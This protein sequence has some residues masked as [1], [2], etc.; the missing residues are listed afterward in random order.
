[1]AP[2]SPSAGACSSPDA[3]PCPTHCRQFYEDMLPYDEFSV[4]L[5]NEDIPHLGRLLRSIDNAE[6]ERL[7]EGMRRWAVTLC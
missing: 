3:D 5:G 4:R 6:Y 2:P 7:Q 1:M